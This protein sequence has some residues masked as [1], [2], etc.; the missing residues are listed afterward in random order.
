MEKA[1]ADANAIEEA[2]Q[3]M[4]VVVADGKAV[5]EEAAANAKEAGEEAAAGAQHPLMNPN[6]SPVGR[7]LI[8]PLPEPNGAAGCSHRQTDWAAEGHRVMDEAVLFLP[9]V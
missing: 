8:V 6:S 9:I 5:D 4:H 7:Y 2:E 1:V 3:R